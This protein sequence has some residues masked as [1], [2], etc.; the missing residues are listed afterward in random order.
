MR[1]RKCLIRRDDGLWIDP[2]ADLGMMIVTIEAPMPVPQTT[3]VELPGRDGV[4]DLSEWAGV[5]RF[6][7]REIHVVLRDLKGN[8]DVL[9]NAIYGRKLRL[10]TDEDTDYYF[11]GRCD[12]LDVVF[13]KP[14]T[15]DIT[16]GVTCHPYKLRQR[17]TVV[18]VTT[19][20]ID[21]QIALKAEQR[22][23]V[24]VITANGACTITVGEVEHECTAG[25]FQL[26]DLLVTST[27]QIVTVAESGITLSFSWQD[28]R[29]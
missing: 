17:S 27:A 13:K 25:T 29:F 9:I 2:L 16:I 12:K 20:A 8:K 7:R 26:P 3:Y 10:F 5:L 22:P 1:L 28:G 6:L 4:L 11:D 14:E 18:E 21:T 15:W 19:T 23:A 24:P